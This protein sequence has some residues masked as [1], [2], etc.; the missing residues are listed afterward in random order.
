MK[1]DKS[2]YDVY[3]NPS[4]TKREIYERIVAEYGELNNSWHLIVTGNS[5]NF[6]VSIINEVPLVRVSKYDLHEC[7]RITKSGITKKLIKVY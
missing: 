3:K 5:F 7:I 1:I 4:I 6:T 2:L